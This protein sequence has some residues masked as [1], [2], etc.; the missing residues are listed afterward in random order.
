MRKLFNHNFFS[1]YNHAEWLATK[2]PLAYLWVLLIRHAALNNDAVLYPSGICSWFDCSPF[3]SE[4]IFQTIHY[5]AILLAV[6]YIAERKMIVT[7]LLMFLLS[8]FVFTLEESNGILNRSSLY[9]M[10]FLAQCIAYFRNNSDLHN[11]RIQF[12]VQLIAAGYMLAAFSKLNETGLAWISDAP[13]AS[14]QIVKG[15]CA[16]YFNNGDIGELNKGIALA[17]FVLQ[18]QLIAKLLFGFSLFLELFAFAGVRNKPST[19]IYGLLL[20]AMHL[21]IFFF[22]HII[23][24]A[25]FFP[26]FIFMV[27]PLYLM[28]AG[29]SFAYKKITRS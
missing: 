11:E 13:Q 19:F 21:G 16:L 29:G 9:T 4:K 22:M 24:V 12:S 1:G 5:A 26:M 17:N 28:Y 6:L 7:T 20:T 15:Y 10:V 27:N 14:I 18:H 23:I 25:I 8:L 3:V 2:I